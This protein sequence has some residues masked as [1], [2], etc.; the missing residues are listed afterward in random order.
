MDLDDFII[1]AF[2][3]IDDT[4]KQLFANI[5]LRQRGPALSD[6]VSSISV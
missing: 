5:Q 1:T 4:M 2:C 6:E 3:M